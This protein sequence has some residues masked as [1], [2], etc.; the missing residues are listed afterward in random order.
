MNRQ[1]SPQGRNALFTAFI[2]G[3]QRQIEGL[4]GDLEF[5]AQTG[6]AQHTVI[7]I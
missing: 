2:K 5:A 7:R 3:I 1:R 6:M 4:G